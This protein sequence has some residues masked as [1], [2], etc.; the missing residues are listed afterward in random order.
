MNE[1]FLEVYSYRTILHSSFKYREV[2]APVYPSL[3]KVRMFLETV[4][5]PVFQDE[6][7]VFFQQV[8]LEDEIGQGFQP[9]K[10]VGR[11]SKDKVE[12]LASALR[13]L[14]TSPRMG[15]HLS[16]FNSCIILQMKA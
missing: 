2:H 10:L 15:R 6:E 13:Y 8:V 5:L 11:V 9:G 14:N 16:V 3:H 1:E 7:S 4:F 12:L